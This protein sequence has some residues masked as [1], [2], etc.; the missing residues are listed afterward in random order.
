MLRTAL[1]SLW[2]GSGVGRTL[3]PRW[4]SGPPPGF[5]SPT[6]TPA[7]QARSAPA[8][9]AP[10]AFRCPTPLL[11]VLLKVDTTSNEMQ[12]GSPSPCHSVWDMSKHLTER[13]GR[14]HLWTC[15]FPLPAGGSLG[16]ACDG[17]SLCAVN[18]P[19]CARQTLTPLP[20][21]SLPRHHLHAHFRAL[22]R[23]TLDLPALGF[24]GPD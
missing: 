1:F 4:P 6:P 20:G 8:C 16:L 13:G 21:R 3:T 5:D 19:F 23:L 11:H 15:D 10:G 18:A 24:W 7:R 17:V 9:S 12:D 2:G 22:V 14:R